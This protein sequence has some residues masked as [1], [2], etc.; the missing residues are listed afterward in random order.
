[1]GQRETGNGPK[2]GFGARPVV[3]I[4]EPKGRHPAGFRPARSAP[5]RMSRV[6]RLADQEEP[7]SNT[8]FLPNQRLTKLHGF[9][10]MLPGESSA[11]SGGLL[12][13]RRAG[14]R[15]ARRSSIRTSSRRQHQHRGTPRPHHRRGDPRPRLPLVT[16]R[17]APALGGAD[18]HGPL[19]LLGGI[20]PAIWTAWRGAGAP[21]Q[22]LLQ[23]RAGRGSAGPKEPARK[24]A[25]HIPG[26]PAR[27]RREKSAAPLGARA[28]SLIRLARRSSAKGRLWSR[29]PY[30]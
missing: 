9:R 3:R 5:K 17:T 22:I 20:G 23:R 11:D 8:L 26:R 24:S 18:L 1:M 30:S 14:A 27:M 12:R 13:R 19:C 4:N 25:P 28:R 10:W 21:G 6:V 16:S 15:P 7:R 2:W 29:A